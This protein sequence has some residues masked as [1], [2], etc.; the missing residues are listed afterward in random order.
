MTVKPLE[1]LYNGKV[2][3]LYAESHRKCVFSVVLSATKEGIRITNQSAIVSTS[4]SEGMCLCMCLQSESAHLNS[5]STM[6][7]KNIFR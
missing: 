5:C 2:P 3:E 4:Q 6:H 1:M 7:Y